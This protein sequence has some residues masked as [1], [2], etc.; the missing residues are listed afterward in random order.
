MVPVAAAIGF[1]YYVVNREELFSRRV[2]DY[3]VE[4]YRRGRTPNPCVRCNTRIKFEELA[5]LA[6]DLGADAVATGHF[7]RIQDDPKSGRRRLLRA[8][9]HDKDQS[10]FLF[11]L[12]REHLALS[13]FPLGEMTKEEVRAEAVKLGLATAGKPESQDVCF[14]EGGD[15]REFL[16]RRMASAGIGEPE[17]E[18]VDKEGKPLG[19][20]QGLSRYTVGQRRG[21]SVASS[22]R[23][24]VVQVDA[25]ANRVTLGS[26]D[27]LMCGSLNLSGARFTGLDDP[28]AARDP[29]EAVVRVRYRHAGAEALVIPRDDGRAVV[30]FRD[31]HRGVS[32][33]QAAVFYDGEILLGGGW[34]DAVGP[35]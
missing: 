25:A 35:P 11:D 29:F 9:D 18:I 3:F 5:L 10:Y 14:V 15:Y 22:R 27:D 6:R 23:L 20:H 30:R 17:G 8:R 19:R 32:P 1:P 13:I 34:I 4:E 28:W 12:S 24:Y 2:L 31:P 16:A 7:A 21:L 26:E 33:G